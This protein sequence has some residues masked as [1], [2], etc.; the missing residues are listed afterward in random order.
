MPVDCL[1]LPKLRRRKQYPTKSNGEYYASHGDYRQEIRQDCLGRCVYCDLHENDLG[2]K[3]NMQIDHFRPAG[4]FRDLANDPHNLAWS[5][6]TCNNKKSDDWP[7]LGTNDTFVGNEGFIDP[8][9]E[10][11]LD[12]FEV[13][14][15]GTI[16]PLK[17]PAKYIEI[18]LG[19]N[20]SFPKRT[21]RLRYEAHQHV[22]K[23]EKD[24]AKLEKSSSLSNEET[25]E[26]SRLQE[27]KKHI[28]ARLDFSLQDD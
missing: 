18:L 16:M 27:K 14:R 4:K 24:I 6:A 28:Q 20:R 8:F 11:R 19:L 7:A 23:L 1:F 15:D 25:A 26:L 9:E 13:R 21:R 12:Y 3:T 10:N 22:R 17:P 5:C 2:G